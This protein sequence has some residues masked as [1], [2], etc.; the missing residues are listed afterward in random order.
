MEN[1]SWK[2]LWDVSIQIDHVIEPRRPDMVIIDKTKNECKI[3]DF[4][5]PF[6][7]RI[8][9]REKDKIKGYNGMK[10]ELKKMWDMPVRVIP[11]VAGALGTTSKKLR[12]QLSLIGTET[13]IMDLQKT[14]VLYSARIVQNVLEV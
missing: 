5:C 8:K 6:D 7:S 14:S 10:R 4:V 1:D 12:H 2:I 13:R 11:E 9:E 3:T